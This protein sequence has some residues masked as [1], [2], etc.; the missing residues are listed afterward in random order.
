MPKSKTRRP[1][2]TAAPRPARGHP[3]VTAQNA[4][5]VATL[6]LLQASLEIV[7]EAELRVTAAA[8]QGEGVQ[9][10]LDLHHHLRSASLGLLVA[11][12]QLAGLPDP[13]EQ[14]PTP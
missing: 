7:R 3:P 2:A 11:Y 4:L 6:A 14:A 8:R 9:E 10:A 12:S 5:E 1:R 13:R